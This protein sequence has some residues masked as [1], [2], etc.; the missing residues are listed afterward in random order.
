[1]PPGHHGDDRRQAVHDIKSAV[2]HLREDY[3]AREYSRHAAQDACKHRIA[4]ILGCD[5][6]VAVSEG[7]VGTDLRALLFDH[8][9]HCRQT[10]KA[11][12][13]QKEER[14][15]RCDPVHPV[16][17]LPVSGISRIVLA[18]KEHP[19]GHFK[20]VKFVLRLAISAFASSILAFASSR[21]FWA[22]FLALSSFLC[23]LSNCVFVCS[24]RIFVCAS[25]FSVDSSCAF[26]AESCAEPS[27][28]CVCMS[29]NCCCIAGRFGSSDGVESICA[30]SAMICSCS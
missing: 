18:R 3:V 17:V 22:S 2:N 25:C 14:E 8:T 28:Y 1:M 12:N 21:S 6:D 24:S 30:W 5:P 16:G 7:F 27:S 11:Y 9:E 10:N 29:A 20:I 19:L 26:C 15:Q 23:W 4:E 13:E